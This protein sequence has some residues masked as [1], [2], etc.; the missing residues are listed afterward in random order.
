MQEALDSKDNRPSV[1]SKRGK[2]EATRGPIDP[3]KGKE[4]SDIEE[5]DSGAIKARKMDSFF[6]LNMH[7]KP[8]EE[9]GTLI[10]HRA[11]HVQIDYMCLLP[12]LHF[13]NIVHARLFCRP[14][15]P[16]FF[17][18]LLPAHVSC[19]VAIQMTPCYAHL[20]LT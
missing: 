9:E 18:V 8:F 6:E 3:K 1:C 12:L 19:L 7:N 11:P 13:T 14:I 15:L 16:L 10:F 2:E 17:L 20:Q 4:E 5:I